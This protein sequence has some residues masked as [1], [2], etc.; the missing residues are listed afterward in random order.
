MIDF[1]NSQL[2]SIHFLNHHL[3]Y[4]FF[5]IFLLSSVLLL[6]TPPHGSPC[7]LWKGA[8]SA[9]RRKHTAVNSANDWEM[10]QGNTS[11]SLTRTQ[12]HCYRLVCACACECVCPLQNDEDEEASF[13]FLYWLHPLASRGAWPPALRFLTDVYEIRLTSPPPTLAAKQPSTL[14]V[15][16]AGNKATLLLTSG[17]SRAVSPSRR[18]F[19]WQAV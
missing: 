11:L 14:P 1:P 3:I 5:V 6:L 17:G 2:G 4:F 18:H 10:K 13:C 9:R 8:T 15:P 16:P 19:D 7:R 12:T